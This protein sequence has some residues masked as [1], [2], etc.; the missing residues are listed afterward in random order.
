MA[1]L[2][3]QRVKSFQV[4]GALGTVSFF[5]GVRT[6]PKNGPIHAPNDAVVDERNRLM[7]KVEAGLTD[8]PPDLFFRVRKLII[9]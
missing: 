7:V 1:M 5:F 2:N 8:A 6:T 4:L 9:G 3:N